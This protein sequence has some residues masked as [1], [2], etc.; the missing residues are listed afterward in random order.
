M[1]KINFEKPLGKSNANISLIPFLNAITQ[2][3]VEE[4]NKTENIAVG[5]DVKIPIGNGLNLDLT[6]NLL[7]C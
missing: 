4:N 3:N 7:V 1:G 6:Y 5:G 2:N